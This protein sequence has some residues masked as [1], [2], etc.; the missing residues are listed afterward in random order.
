VG[1]AVTSADPPRVVFGNGRTP[2]PPADLSDTPPPVTAPAVAVSNDLPAPAALAA[3]PAPPAAPTM[4][5][6]T[7]APLLTPTA[8]ASGLSSLWGL[9][10]LILAPLAGI[11]LGYRQARANKAASELK[12]SLTR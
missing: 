4:M 10:G 6:R 2:G 12:S 3:P 9:A 5:Q 8:P 11:L 1:A 7:M